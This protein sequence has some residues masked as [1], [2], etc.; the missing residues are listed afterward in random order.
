LWV[1]YTS[2]F[3]D[4]GCASASSDERCFLGWEDL[5]V[6]SNPNQPKRAPFW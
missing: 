6:E 4:L 2:M 3:H 1:R 5:G